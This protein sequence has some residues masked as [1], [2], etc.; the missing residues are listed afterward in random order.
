M[1]GVEVAG[2]SAFKGLRNAILALAMGAALAAGSL[3]VAVPAE[4]RVN[5]PRLDSLSI[6]CGALQDEADRLIAEYKNASNARREE[7]LAR[8]RNIGSDWHAI[9]KGVFGSISLTV[10]PVVH[11]NLAVAGELELADGGSGGG[12]M[13]PTVGSFNKAGSRLAR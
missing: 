4:A 10:G 5:G 6:G 9:C 1:A 13:Q 12:P 11:H 3:G 2:K 8:L 7:I